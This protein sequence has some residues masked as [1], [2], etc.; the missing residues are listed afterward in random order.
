[1]AGCHWVP[2]TV[3]YFINNKPY[4]PACMYAHDYLA[5]THDRDAIVSF[6]FKLMFS[7]IKLCLLLVSVQA[8]T[9]LCWLGVFMQY[10][11]NHR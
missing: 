10:T 9:C 7:V 1:M 2:A 5:T 8:S 3:E 6:C 4:K 11:Y